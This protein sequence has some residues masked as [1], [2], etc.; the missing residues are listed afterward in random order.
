[1]DTISGSA[2][3]RF[4]NYVAIRFQLYNSLFTA[5]P[6]HKIEKTGI[7]L[8]LF[9]L[10]CEEGYQKGQSPS[11]IIKD[12]F[13][14]HT[15]YTNEKDQL[16]LLFRFIQYAERQVVLFDALEDAAF[17]EVIDRNSHPSLN[18][19][20]NVLREKK[21]IG[22]WKKN[23]EDFSIRIVLTAHPTQFYPGEVL[24]IIYDLSKALKGAD[25]NKVNLYLQQ[26]GK[27]P[28]L[29]KTKPTPFDEAR[30][31][32]WYLE[33]VLYFASGRII[34][35]Y[36][37][38]FPAEKIDNRV[39]QL[40][41]WPGG[42]RDGNP[43]VTAD[44]TLE[45]AASLRNTIIKCYYLDIRQLRRR[46]TFKGVS[47]IIITLEKLLYD[48][49][50]LPTDDGELTAEI[51]LQYLQ[52]IRTIIIN[53]HN[54]L[55]L[56]LVD[57]L[58]AK[59]EVFGLYF[60]SLDIRQ[61]ST[62]HG[63]VFEEIAAKTNALPKDY[64]TKTEKEKQQLLFN[65]SETVEPSV[66]ELPL[67]Q[68]TLASVRAVK[69]IQSKNGVLGC[70]RYIIS[71]TKTALN[72]IEVYGL[73]LLSSFK[74][75][76]LQVDIIPLFETIED[77]QHASSVMKDLYADDNYKQHLERRGNKQTIMVGFS[78]GTKDG[79]YLM[80][81]WGIYK[82]KKELTQI[83]AAA[84]IEVTF[85]DGRGGPPARGGGKTN[86]FYSSMGR[87]IAGKAI[88]LTIQG[89]TVSSNFGT[90]DSAQF[91]MEQLLHAGL[92][93][94][95]GLNNAQTFTRSQEETFLAMATVG[96]KMYNDLKH[97]PQFMEYMSALTPL[98]YFAETNISSR[99]SKRGGSAK[100]TLNDLRAIPYVG[101]WTLVK[102]NVTGY[103]GVGTALQQMEQEGKWNEVESLYANSP[104]FKTLVDN[105]EMV[106]V[107]TYFPL[108]Q[109]LEND[110]QFGELW[111]MMRDEYEL[112]KRYVLKL[113]GE[114]ELM[115]NLPVERMSIGMRERI[116]LP[117]ASIQQYALAE[118]RNMN[119]ESELKE[120]FE[121]LVIRSSFGIINAGR[122]SV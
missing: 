62:V 108:T 6:F 50:F 96:L 28:F 118:L 21:I 4:N 14:A 98:P 56:Y 95:L 82:A 9:L 23:I 112:A 15:T 31:L 8:S 39:L 86:R 97:H 43:N 73:F 114:K 66:L 3:Q 51:L 10:Q 76:E 107:K 87:D 122:N 20:S 90:I 74:K 7:L 47:P 63:K 53:D 45:V 57:N 116:V 65:I 111:K 80:A 121:K 58:I 106:M 85:F 49:L 60:A 37:S 88:Q 2:L 16:D 52:E 35:A 13:T 44:S 12:F 92:M 5:L 77:L 84:G 83:S 22:D 29:K 11:Q 91:N 109:H 32:I 41:F 99:P 38:L 101:S 1:M 79:G 36:K 26:L 120:S 102:Q 27:T 25:T 68:D 33:N 89:Q 119:D 75:E 93:N 81:N 70:N 24:G 78:D 64:T 34:T 67:H 117:L 40:G 55:F 18:Q 59:V 103:Y 42:D 100:L 48:H 19:L 104:Y 17:T 30:S 54:S 115:E 105:C 72:I 113:S 94:E 71:Q 110:K 61:E 46:L 69:T